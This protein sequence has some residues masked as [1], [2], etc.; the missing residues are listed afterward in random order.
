MT[1]K[2][3]A[4]AESVVCFSCGAEAVFVASEG[5][6]RHANQPWEDQSQFCDRYGY[7]VQPKAV[8]GRKKSDQ[9]YNDPAKVQEL[10]YILA[11]PENFT[12]RYQLKEILDSIE[13]DCAQDE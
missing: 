13:S 10:L 5:V 7:P 6:W 11:R 9:H 3:G 8:R 12:L 1:I 2:N 4:H